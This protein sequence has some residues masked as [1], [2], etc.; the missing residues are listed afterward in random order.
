MY[1]QRNLS[2]KVIYL[3]LLTSDIGVGNALQILRERG[4]LGKTIAIGRNKEKTID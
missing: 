2:E 1:Y 3:L 4:M